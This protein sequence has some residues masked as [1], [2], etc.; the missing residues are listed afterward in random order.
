[1]IWFG[2]GGLTPQSSVRARFSFNG[3]E[4]PALDYGPF[5]S[6]KTGAP[7]SLCPSFVPNAGSVGPWTLS[8]YVNNSP[9]PFMTVSFTVSGGAGSGTTATVP[10][11]STSFG[12]TCAGSFPG[13]WNTNNVGGMAIDPVRTDGLLTGRFSASGGVL[14]N[15]FVIGRVLTGV[16]NG[17]NGFLRWLMAP[18]G[19]SMV[20]LPNAFFGPGDATKFATNPPSS[21]VTPCLGTGTAALWVGQWD[22]V[23][24]GTIRA[25]MN[26]NGSVTFTV[27]QNCD[28][29]GGT[30]TGT[31]SGLSLT[32]TYSGPTSSGTFSLAFPS[33]DIGNFSGSYST[34]ESGPQPW[35]GKNRSNGLIPDFLSDRGFNGRW[36]TPYGLLTLKV[37]GSTVTGTYPNGGTVTGSV[38]QG[39]L[40]P[41]DFGGG[42]TL[43]GSYSDLSSSGSIS[44]RI[45]AVNAPQNDPYP[46]TLG[47]TFYGSSTNSS[48]FS[49]PWVGARAG[50][51]SGTWNTQLG[52]MTGSQRGD[53]KWVLKVAGYSFVGNATNEPAGGNAVSGQFIGPFG[54]GGF[55]FLLNPDGVSFSGSVAAWSHIGLYGTLQATHVS[56]TIGPIDLC[57]TIRPVTTITT[58]PAGLQVRVDLASLTAPV[59]RSWPSGEG[60][61]FSTPTPQTLNS[62][63][64]DFSLWNYTLNAGGG[65]LAP[66]S[67]TT[68][69][70]VFKAGTNGAGPGGFGGL[71]TSPNGPIRMIPTA[72]NTVE[73]LFTA[74]GPG[75]YSGFTCTAS[76][77]TC[78]G[79][80]FTPNGPPGTITITSAG[81]SLTGTIARPGGAG[82]IPVSGTSTG[83]SSE[84]A[85]PR[86]TFS[87]AMTTIRQNACSA[88]LPDPTKTAFYTNDANITH[89][90]S[91]AGVN[92]GDLI[93]VTYTG[94]GGVRYFGQTPTNWS[95]IWV[96]Y[97]LPVSPA[98]APQGNW[99]VSLSVN[100]QP[101]QGTAAPFTLSAPPPGQVGTGGGPGGGGTGGTSCPSTTNLALLKATSISSG[102]GKELGNNDIINEPNGFGFHTISEGEPWWQV[103]LGALSTIC[104]VRMYNRADSEFARAATVRVRLSASE[105]G[106][107]DTAYAHDGTLWGVGG[108]PPLVVT[109]QVANKQARYVRI[110]L[111]GTSVLHLREVQVF[112]ISPSSG[113]G[114]GGTPGGGG[115][116]RWRD[117]WWRNRRHRRRRDWRLSHID[118]ARECQHL[119]GWQNGRARVHWRRRNVAARLRSSCRIRGPGLDRH[120]CQRYL[121][122]L[123]GLRH[124]RT[125]RVL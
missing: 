92:P 11:N 73:G 89:W 37:T 72:G 54:G 64:Y 69:T 96:C 76:G 35:S 28:F 100:N 120:Q 22:T 39:N 93:G 86:V 67:S 124:Q 103:D 1:M 46:Q 7:Y 80:A 71:W 29:P 43:T 98:A 58:V 51:W 23:P 94:P 117:A 61:G 102:T 75:G 112:G 8:V 105:N 48:G 108:Q 17:A 20:G 14:G 106:P 16:T 123:P 41:P 70:A 42:V 88:S 104:E 50:D 85:G 4:Q 110:Q 56:D 19:A 6:F 78:T 116:G 21:P 107:F 121:Y 40:G 66:P 33:N 34:G 25:R 101:V 10:S 30:F 18:S 45:N 99:T 87:P 84:P 122:R 15:G 119:R 49:A 26:L 12:P 81:P 27:P 77:N 13:S 9:I 118:C 63:L 79:A 91:I 32:G 115:T 36:Y 95:S 31:A 74:G 97:T 52:T 60:H 113:S 65:I 24:F 5:G 125:R 55:L 82:T 3:T 53:G 111:V 114:G 83:P 57:S 68:Y 47:A 2:L 44:L 59:T 38:S 109:S 62:V 90:V